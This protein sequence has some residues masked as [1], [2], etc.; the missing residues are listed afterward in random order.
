MNDFI[1]LTGVYNE[2]VY[3]NV[4]KVGLITS[5]NETTCI[6]LD[7]KVKVYVKQSPQEVVNMILKTN[8]VKGE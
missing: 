6:F 7:D 4:N 8:N 2:P 5:N 1:E 3:L